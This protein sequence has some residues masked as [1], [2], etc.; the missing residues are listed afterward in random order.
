[1]GRLHGGLELEAPRRVHAACAREQF[2]RFVDERG[3]PARR[4]LCRERH[5]VA[6]SVATGVATRMRMQHEREQAERLGLARQERSGQSAEPDALIGELA[7]ARLRSRRI[8]PALGE[9]GVEHREDFAEALGELLALGHAE[10]NPGIADAVLRAHQALAHGGGRDQE[11]GADRRGVEAEHRLQDERRAHAG[12]DRRMRAR[13]HE[14]QAL[15]RNK[16]ITV[17][18]LGELLGKQ[19]ERRRRLFAGP[20]AARRIDQLSACHGEEPSLGRA[21]DALHRPFGERAGECL[22]ERVLCAGD[23]ARAR[24]EE[25]HE[26]AV[27][28]ARDGLRGLRYI[29]Q[30]GRTSIEPCAAPGQRLAQASAASRSGTSIM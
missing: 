17:R 5:E 19:R 15:V 10:R 22:G 28:R 23:I 13:E 3:V 21:R 4:I 18:R 30:T 11:C 25:G 12:V 26:L 27:A 16:R 14:P 9:D 8:G 29:C 20:S 7:R 6:A 24:G 2:L 1:M